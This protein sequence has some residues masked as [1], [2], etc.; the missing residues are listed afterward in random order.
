MKSP[1][2]TMPKDL[3]PLDS[4]P[5]RQLFRESHANEAFWRLAQFYCTQPDLGSCSVASC[6]MILNAMPI[7][8][9]A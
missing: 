8:S 3:I 1:F 2:L 9:G 5:G 6:L 4:M 7:S